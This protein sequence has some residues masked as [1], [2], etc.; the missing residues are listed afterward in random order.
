[1]TRFI[2]ERQLEQNYLWCSVYN[3]ER[4]TGLWRRFFMIDL[5]VKGQDTAVYLECV[6]LLYKN[7]IT[8]YGGGGGF[9]IIIFIFVKRGVLCYYFTNQSEG[10]INLCSFAWRVGCHVHSEETMQHHEC[11]S[12]PRLVGI[13][14]RWLEFIL[15]NQLGH[16]TT[17]A[18]FL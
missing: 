8:C 7:T 4:I 1:M 15:H 17:V 3:V 18:Y 16:T 11:I 14:P 9:I 12:E 6:C 2:C 13:I 10:T 5:R